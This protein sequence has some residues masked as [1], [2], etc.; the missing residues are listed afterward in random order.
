MNEKKNYI[1][2]SMMSTGLVRKDQ[3]IVVGFSGGPD[4]LTLLTGLHLLSEERGLDLTLVPVHVNHMIRG[5]AADEDQR[6]AEEMCRE[7]GIRCRSFVRDCPQYAAEHGLTE[8][9]AGRKIRYGLFLEIAREL[10]KETG[11][12]PA[13][14]VAH[15]ADDQ[16]ETV[17]F[18]IMRGTGIRGLSA[19]TPS[20]DIDGY[21][22]IRPLLAV[23]RSEIEAYI[24]EQGLEPCVDKTNFQDEYSRNHLRLTVIPDI[25]K[26][27][28]PGFRE[29]L[30]RLADNARDDED[31]IEAMARDAFEKMRLADRKVADLKEAAGFEETCGEPASGIQVDARQFADCH[32]A[33]QSRICRGIF[34]SMGIE[35]GFS[36]NIMTEIASVAA[37]TNPSAELDLPGGCKVRRRYDRLIFSGASEG[38]GAKLQGGIS[39]SVF[40][41]YDDIPAP[42]KGQI[43]AA[44]DLESLKKKYP[45]P[46]SA[47]EI[48]NRRPGDFID[49]GSGRKKIQDMLVDMKVPREYRDQVRMAAIGSEV[50]W[51]LPD[52]RMTSGPLSRK[53]R[54]SGAFK[55][56]PGQASVVLALVFMRVMCFTEDVSN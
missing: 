25:E 13:I 7:M 5:A 2:K 54:F 44:F 34:Q 49:I 26:N 19:M 31:L 56:E 40:P 45:D 28:N 21:E 52:E 15:N 12:R 4:S 39:V 16:S 46:L 55:A 53:G 50:L 20:R 37:S 14:A 1:L 6:R 29:N 9:E 23:S 27:V 10:E 11:R 43:I 35:E 30:R 36:R 38:A 17:L 8:E 47:L 3:V 18:R 41:S 42:E 33:L 24:E 51:I 22:L 32:R 48:R